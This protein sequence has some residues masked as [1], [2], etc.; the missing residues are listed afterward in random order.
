MYSRL[1]C[2][3]TTFSIVAFDPSTRD[4]GIAVHSRYFSVGSVVP[5]AEAGVGAVATQS[6]VNVSYGPRGLQLLREGLTVNEVI[7]RL[8]IQDEARDYRQLGIVDSKGNVAV[9]TGKKCLKWAGSKTGKNYVA[10]GNILAGEKVVDNMTKGFESTKDDLAGKLIAALEGGDE[11][12]G[13]IRG[14]QSASLL[15]VRKDGGRGGYGDRYIDL[16]VEDHLNPIRELRRLLN[17][18]RVYY[19]I[20]ESEDKLT[21]GDLE[22]ALAIIKKAISLNQNI[23]EA[24]VDLALICLKLKRKEEAVKALKKALRINPK[25]KELIKQFPD[26]GLMEPDEELARAMTDKKFV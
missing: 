18:S 14:R 4:L 26:I 20:D 21:V 23:D 3:A 22:S 16:R 11:A 13:D 8:T 17:L 7:E 6:F 1:N 9:F 12:G 2:W 19:L 5:W 10:L 24:Y 25:L 15:V